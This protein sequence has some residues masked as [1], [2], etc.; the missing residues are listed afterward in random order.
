MP[1]K[2]AI[3]GRPGVG[4]TYLANKLAKDQNLKN[5]STDD[6]I[7]SVPFED[8]PTKIMTD[9]E[10]VDQD[11][12]VEGVQVARMIKKGF[13][14]DKIYIVE[15]NTRLEP[16]HK[17]L[18]KINRNAIEALELNPLEGVEVEHIQNDIRGPQ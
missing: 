15:A 16:K 17:A 1:K 5:I 18:A 12:V 7:G 11:Y 14:P 3:I 13:K 6:Y 10:T 2:I 4:K 9:L 8:V